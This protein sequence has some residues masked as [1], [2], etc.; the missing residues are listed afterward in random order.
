MS[1]RL[2]GTALLAGCRMISVVHNFS[3]PVV[4]C[5]S[6]CGLQED[7]VFLSHVTE[8]ACLQVRLVDLFGQLGLQNIKLLRGRSPP[9]VTTQT[10]ILQ[11]S[12]P[13]LRR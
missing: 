2:L 6:D 10:S 9:P 3:E 7:T 11:E 1:V 12:A 13:W 4:D 5:S 8:V